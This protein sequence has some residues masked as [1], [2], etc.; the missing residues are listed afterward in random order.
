[1]S[2]TEEFKNNILEWDELK[3]KKKQF[4]ENIKKLDSRMN[5]LKD[6]NIEFMTKKEIDICNLDDGKIKLVRRVNRTIDVKKSN[7]PTILKHFY[8]QEQN[9]S[10][11]DS[12]KVVEKVMNFIKENYSKSTETMSLTR[13]YAQTQEE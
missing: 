1:M 4:S 3:A 5:F 2:D 10:D 7:L 11:Y 8:T 12:D 6:R 13:T 9:M